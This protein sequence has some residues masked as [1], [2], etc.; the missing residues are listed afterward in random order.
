MDFQDLASRLGL[1][2]E[3]FMELVELFIT[4]TQADIAKI[5]SGVQNNNPDE[6][7]AASH[8]IKGASGNL[9][10]DD[11]FELT[12]IMEMQAKSGSLDGFDDFI[13]DLE[14]KLDTLNPS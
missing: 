7:A 5:K 2:E 3:D 10:F 12:K 6:A 1:D 4:T 8:S 13:A 14:K 11:M 9:G